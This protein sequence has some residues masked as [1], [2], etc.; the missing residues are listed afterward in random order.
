M[1]INGGDD[2]MTEGAR[3]RILALAKRLQLIAE[4]FVGG[5]EVSLSI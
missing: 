2:E 3:K 5:R 1:I 4:S